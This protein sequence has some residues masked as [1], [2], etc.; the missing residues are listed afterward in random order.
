MR[1]KVRAA[2]GVLWSLVE[3]GGGEGVSFLVF[4]VLARLVAPAD[5]GVVALAGIFVAFV[6]VFLAQGFSDAVIQRQDLEPDHCSTAFWVNLAIAGVFLTLTLLLAEPI[7]AL[8]HQPRLAAVLCWMSPVFIST[9][10]NSIHQAL[11][12]RRLHFASFALRALAGITCG[13]AV[14]VTMA[15]RGHGVWSLVGQQLTNGLVSILVIWGTSAWRPS[16]RFSARCFRDMAGFSF[17]VIAGNLVRFVYLKADVFL[18]GLFIDAQQLGYYTL[19]QRLL[20]TCGL[21]TQS[22]VLPIVLPLLARLQN[23]RER[24][25]EAFLTALRMTQL[26][27][28]P[29]AVGLGVVADPLIPLFFGAQWAPGVPLLE[30]MSLIGF[31]QL[32]SYFTGPA[33]IA[34]NRPGVVLRLSLVQMVVMLVIFVPAA[35]SF[36]V[37][38][39]AAATTLLYVAIIP[40]HAIMLRRVAGIALWSVMLRCRA[41][42]G[43]GAV[44]AGAVLLL[45]AELAA[46]LPPAPLLVVLIAAGTVVYVGALGAFGHRELRELLDL[47]VGAFGRRHAAAL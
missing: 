31:M 35:M 18:I 13:G 21:V 36:G 32:F 43:A 39:I 11:F 24:F 4:L 41:A 40:F 5:F 10:L 16:L 2:R 42:I 27:W 38:G 29:L 28:L 30:I 25:R 47:V 19:V 23:D 15:L 37:V 12:K 9:A 33:L 14:G 1:M 46:T 22:S 26:V 34:L 7:A 3:Y 44:M 8:F 17:H 20:I 6:Q 45:K